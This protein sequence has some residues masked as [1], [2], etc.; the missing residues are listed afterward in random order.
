M[1]ATN[2]FASSMVALSVLVVLGTTTVLMGQQVAPAVTTPA[3]PAMRSILDTSGPVE[4][5]QQAYQ[6]AEAHRAASVAGQV[7]MQTPV[8]SPALAPATASYAPQAAGVVG[9]VPGTV[10]AYGG[11]A[12]LPRRG[13]WAYRGLY[14]YPY[15]AVRVQVGPSGY[16]PSWSIMANRIPSYPYPGIVDQPIGHV[17]TPTGPNGYTY[18][19]VYPSNLRPLAV[20]PATQ[21]PE[22]SEQAA[23][24]PVPPPSANPP[25]PASPTAE[26]IPVPPAQAGPTAF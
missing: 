18:R 7:Q 19:P 24:A 6:R 11:Y 2:R 22:A 16:A 26:P 4:A 5:G 3:T 9:Y 12:Y 23:P 14:G 17:L 8:A 21:A 20:P 13:V 1:F 25:A 10:A 15:P